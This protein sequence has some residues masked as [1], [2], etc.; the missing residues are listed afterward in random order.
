MTNRII[1]KALTQNVL[2]FTFILIILGVAS[3][4]GDVSSPAAV[5]QERGIKAPV[6]PVEQDVRGVDDELD[7]RA[8]CFPFL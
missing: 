1:P 6:I 3:G 2:L 8:A 4:C 7:E 5:P